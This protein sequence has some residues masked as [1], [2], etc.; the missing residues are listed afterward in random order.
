MELPTKKQEVE[1]DNPYFLILMSKPKIGKTTL[2]EGLDDCL[3]VDLEKGGR[4]AKTM[5]VEINTSGELRD[6]I[7]SLA[8]AKKEKGGEYVY[9]YIALDTATALEEVCLPIALAN[10]RKLPIGKNYGLVT[11]DN[12]KNPPVRLAKPYY[13]NKS[14]LDLPDG[15][16]YRYTREAFLSILKAFEPYCK[17]LILLGHTKDKTI[18]K[19]GKELN[20]NTIDLTGKLERI[21]ASKADVLGYVY[22]EGDTTFISFE[23]GGDA[24]IGGRSP[25][26]RGKVIE[27]AKAV[28]DEE[29]G[30]ITYIETF[31]DRIYLPDNK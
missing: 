11:V 12:T 2:L 18:N 22:R 14:I 8:K 1:T 10:Y 7:Q 20:E 30:D 13:E 23:S 4:Y 6:L 9:K 21:V 15:A 29:S 17:H 31:M 5:R 27:V 28:R 16:G 19:K 26:L 3:H 24:I 25:H